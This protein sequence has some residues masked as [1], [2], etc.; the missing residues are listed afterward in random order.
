M[1]RA[2][3][4]GKFCYPQA[5]IEKNSGRTGRDWLVQIFWTYFLIEYSILYTV[6]IVCNLICNFILGNK[7][8]FSFTFD[9]CLSITD[10]SFQENLLSNNSLYFIPIRGHN[11]YKIISTQVFAISTQ[12]FLV[13]PLSISKCWD[14]SQ[15]SKLP[16]HAS[17]IAL[18]P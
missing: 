7:T 10:I 1:L 4:N 16:L 3:F 17:H 15:D 12:V 8:V 5:D 14:G 18:P 13:F 2:E 11:T 9:G 6:Q